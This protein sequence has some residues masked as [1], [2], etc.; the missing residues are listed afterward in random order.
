[1]MKREKFRAPLFIGGAT[2][3]ITLRIVKRW[4]EYSCHYITVV[5]SVHPAVSRDLKIK[6]VVSLHDKEY[7]VLTFPPSHTTD[8]D[9]ISEYLCLVE[10]AQHISVLTPQEA[11]QLIDSGAEEI[12]EPSW[13]AR[14]FGEFPEREEANSSGS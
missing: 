13:F 6:S 12:A 8:S 10:G 14:V 7:V 5:E 2:P 4:R 3:A 1:M 9:F 11:A